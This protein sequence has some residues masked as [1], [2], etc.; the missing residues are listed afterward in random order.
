[1]NQQ[2]SEWLDNIDKSIKSDYTSQHRILSFEEYLALVHE[3]PMRQLRSSAQYIC[4]MMDHFG[5]DEKEERFHLFDQSFTDSHLRLVGQEPVQNYVYKILQSFV[6][7]GVNNKLILL[8]GPNGSSKSSFINCLIRGMEEYSTTDEG[9]MYK[10]HWIFP[11]NASGK[12]GFGLGDGQQKE[13]PHTYAKLDDED[14]SVRI[15]CDLKD[16]P[17]FL[18]PPKERQELFDKLDLPSSFRI[19]DYLRKGDLSQKS[20]MIFEALLRSYGGDFRKVVKH[21]QVERFYV[22]KR[23]REGAAAVEPQA[24]VDAHAKQITMDRSVGELPVALHSLNLF[25]MNGDLIDGNRGV[26]EYNDLLKR[27]IEAFKYLLVTCE[28]GTVTVAGTTAFLDA[29]LIGSC[30]EKQLDAFKDYPDFASFKARIEL[31]RVPYLLESGKERAIYESQAAKI[32]GD[33]HVSPHVL[34]IAALWA[35]LCRLK[36]PNSSH[37]PSN[38]AYLINSLTPLEKARL[39]DS[40]QL[41]DRLS[42]EDRQQLRASREDIMK[43]YQS[44]P[45]YE[46]RMGPSAREIKLVLFEAL[47]AHDKEI[48]S[49]LKL[50]EVLENFVTKT[51]EHEFLRENIVEGYHDCRNFINVVREH[52]LNFV[53]DEVRSSLGIHDDQQYA[54]FLTKYV[55][56][57]SAHLKKEKIRN[58]ITGSMESPDE[59][60]LNEFEKVANVSGDKEKFRQSIIT[61]IGVYSLDNPSDGKSPEYAKIF[62]DL[63]K[64]IRDY[65]LN[66]HTALLRKVNDA[67]NLYLTLD[68]PAKEPQTEDAKE[69]RDMAGRLIENMISRFHYNEVS[70]REAISFLVRKR[71]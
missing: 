28:T 71:Y 9:A 15:S 34:E 22:S 48:L 38:R 3:A 36:K 1:M 7:E 35:V 32:A 49:P 65:Y 18:V 62:P 53:D 58:A 67:M 14:I 41:P 25:E 68:E 37:Y 63:I 47:E 59:S 11:R 8:H 33:H 52:Y 39:Y 64:R 21:I 50:F 24:H 42:P 51:S 60:L 61:N 57:V 2:S 31:V 26:V 55:T 29:V 23:Y 5:Y 20:K 6:R 43:E 66:E 46:G 12:M 27:P 44:I 40:G 30:N 69:A 17:L 70:A 45:Y 4:D 56:H 54:D 13:E 16:H 19:S 10:F